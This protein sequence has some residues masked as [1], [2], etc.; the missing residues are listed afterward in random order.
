MYKA[1]KLKLN[2]LYEI[3]FSP[4]KHL[5]FHFTQSLPQH[6]NGMRFSA[7]DKEGELIATN[8]IEMLDIL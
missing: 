6:P 3:T 8:V 5:I 4:E 2:G 7:Y 1:Q